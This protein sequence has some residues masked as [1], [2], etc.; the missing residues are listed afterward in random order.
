MSADWTAFLEQA[1]ARSG[2]AGIADFGDA[3][4]EAA[5][6]RAGTVMAPLEHLGIIRVEGADGV[7]LLQGQV[8]SDVREV[9]PQRSQASGLCSPKGRLL[10]S[11]RI[12]QEG[13]ALVLVLPRSLLSPI[14]NRLRMFVLRA[15]ARLSDASD[16]RVVL[17]LQGAPETLGPALADWLPEL[18][19]APDEARAGQEAVAV[20]LRDAGQPRF[21]LVCTAAVAPGI[22]AAAAA[23]GARPVGRAAWSL[24]DI[25]AGVPV[26]E[27]TTSD[28]FVPQMVN[29]QALGGVSFTKG[30]YAGQEV[31]ARMQYLGKLK[32]R[33]Y[34]AHADAAETP[35]PGTDL[36]AAADASGQSVG[37]VV[38]AAPRPDG[39]Q[40]L[41]AVIQIEAA[42]RDTLHLGTKDGPALIL[43]DL[44]YPLEQEA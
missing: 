18:P 5:A 36:Y 26:V 21:L 28:A 30:C 9:G 29:L 38:A 37:K 13:D 15:D 27:S 39:G 41:L 7:T 44:P 22:W 12:L 14:L 1:G 32:R 17:G 20:R 33:M 34:R 3:A 19:P 4:A 31:V 43:E 25:A 23:A 11:F 6:A 35:A 42:D 40:A 2:E 24:T 8:T 10:A 16:E